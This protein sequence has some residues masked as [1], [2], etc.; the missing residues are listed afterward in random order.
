MVACLHPMSN[1]STEQSGGELVWR[2]EECKIH[3][4]NTLEKLVPRGIERKSFMRISSL[5]ITLSRTSC[6]KSKG[7][8]FQRKWAPLLSR[9]SEIT[10]YCNVYSRVLPYAYSDRPNSKFK[11]QFS[12]IQS[13]RYQ[14]PHSMIFENG[15]HRKSNI[16]TRTSDVLV[17]YCALLLL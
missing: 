17:F 10:I 5:H 2:I 11:S 12:F 15:R 13:E 4:Q 16:K 8:H 9:L 1:W 3:T 6:D 14:K 7:A